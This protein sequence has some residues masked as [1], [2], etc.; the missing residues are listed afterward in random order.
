MPGTL[1]KVIAANAVG[2]AN[3]IVAEIQPETRPTAG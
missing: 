1:P 3:P 2:A